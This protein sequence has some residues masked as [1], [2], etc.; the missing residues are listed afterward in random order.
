[1][2]RFTKITSLIIFI[3]L[4]SITVNANAAWLMIQE[5]VDPETMECPEGLRPVS[6]VTNQ[7]DY[8]ACIPHDVGVDVDLKEELEKSEEAQG[9]E[10]NKV[11][12]EGPY[13]GTPQ[14]G[15]QFN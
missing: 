8:T 10:F 15:P 12:H 13:E 1:M 6:I 2:K 4:L 14:E 3:A 5:G 11:P 7:S 9:S